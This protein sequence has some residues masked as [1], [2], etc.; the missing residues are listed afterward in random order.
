[1]VVAERSLEGIRHRLN[2]LAQ[3]MTPAEARGYVRARAAVVVWREVDHALTVEG[4]LPAWGRDELFRQT[5]NHVVLQLSSELVSL[6][7][8]QVRSQRRA[9]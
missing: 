4:R 8:S 6:P 7:R 2:P 3:T 1:L 9:A 5:T